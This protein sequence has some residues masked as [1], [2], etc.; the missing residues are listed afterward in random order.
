MSNRLNGPTN[1]HS[2]VN[3]PVVCLKELRNSSSVRA[4]RAC[5]L[6]SSIYDTNGRTHW[7]I[8]WPF[9]HE[10]IILETEIERCHLLRVFASKQDKDHTGPLIGCRRSRIGMQSYAGH[11]SSRMQ[12]RGHDDSVSRGKGGG[13]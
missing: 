1:Q 11:T 10:E 12:G 9:R 2:A 13:T 8:M 5:R 7:N 6:R 3:F 4:T